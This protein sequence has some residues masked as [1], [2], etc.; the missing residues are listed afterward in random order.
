M[1]DHAGLGSRLAAR[2]GWLAAAALGVALVTTVGYWLGAT[3]AGLT[4]ISPLPGTT[5]TGEVAQV[6]PMS[7]TVTRSD[8]EARLTTGV[9]LAKLVVAAAATAELRVDVAW[10]NVL[11]ATRV[12]GSPNAQLSLG[13]Y[14]PVHTGACVSVPQG[15]VLVRPAGVSP[16]GVSPAGVSPVVRPADVSEPADAP[17]VSLTDTDGTTLCAALD[18]SATGS[19]SVS[20]TGKLLL[21]RDLVAGYLVPGLDGSAPVPACAPASTDT[22]GWCQPASIASPAQRALYLVAS[23]TTPGDHPKGQ[24]TDLSSLT[25]FIAARRLG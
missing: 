25:F 1:S 16:A 7:A 21:A 9:A 17:L 4:S 12:L 10:T 19:G 3:G 23:V 8:G 6:V 20:E 15:H 11:S 5:S 22:G 24:Q 14:H 18:E 2:R 13:L